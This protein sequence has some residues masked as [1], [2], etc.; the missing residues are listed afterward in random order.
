MGIDKKSVNAWCIHFDHY[1]PEDEG[2]RESLLALGNG[3]LVSRAAAPESKDDPIHYPGT[4]LVGCYNELTTHIQGKDVRNESMV[5]LP[6]WLPLS[7]KVNGGDWFSLE[8]VTI[9]TYSQTLDL[10][11]SLL[12]RQVL[13]TD[14]QG[15]ETLLNERRFV[16]MADPHLMGLALEVTAKNWTGTL[17]VAS[18]LDGRVFN[19][20]VKRYSPYNR[21]HLQ[22]SHAGVW[23]EDGMELLSSTSQSKTTIA[24]AAR[25]QVRKGELQADLTREEKLEPDQVFTYYQ[26]PLEEGECVAI[27]K[28]AALYSSLNYP[29]EECRP[30]ACKSL[31]LASGFEKLLEAHTKAWEHLWRKCQFETEDQQQLRFFRLHIFQILQNFSPHT[32]G[33]DAGVAPSGWQGEEYNGQVFWDELFV[34]PFLTFHFPESARSLLRYRYRR[35]G[36]ARQMAQQDGY[37]GAMFPWRSASDG[38]EETPSFQLNLLS[39]RWMEDH[40]C[41]QRHIGAIIAYNVW[42][43]VQVTG[44]EEFLAECGAELFL[45]IARFWA[46]IAQL[47][48]A[49]GR[50]EIHGVAGPDEYHTLHPQTQKPGLS[51]N[52]Y[53]NVMAVWVLSQ[54]EP[55]L[56][57]LPPNRQQE[58]Q[59]KLKLTPEE[60]EL[61]DT[62]S[63]KMRIVFNPDGTL[64]QFEG[65]DQLREFDIEEFRVKHG[66]ERLDWALEAM[67]DSV[68]RYRVAKQADT[69]LLLYLFSPAEVISLLDQL[70]YHMDE[71]LLLRTLERHLSFTSHESTLSRVVYAG[72]YAHF[73]LATSWDFFWEAQQVDWSPEDKGTAEGIHL[74]P[75]GGT[76]AVLQHHYL[77]WKVRAEELEANPSLPDSLAWVN[78][79]VCFRNSDLLCKAV[80]SDGH[81]L[82]LGRQA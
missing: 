30:K 25:T 66:K 62:I 53:T 17:E 79:S 15:Q 51:N 21:H 19:N 75:M 32:V 60:F 67:G 69:P 81:S 31:Q 34:F 1:D 45:E 7:F 55:L 82:F 33:I 48:P 28:I 10:Q 18:G 40:T 78:F 35:L 57:Q 9:Q 43:Y 26:V 49:T 20:K 3:L 65:F 8:K 39:G 80:N 12:T 64:C 11:Q 58:L 52:T 23:G 68:Q 74:G 59:D 71:D 14:G 44:D 6:N 5:N 37:A 13:F 46:S 50:Y 54:A 72:A 16:S 29:P 42:Y 76:L 36:A 47:N 2:R 24:L 61:W 63:R 73:D 41:L 22:V 27:E 56:G 38:H 70:G 77:G 4:Y